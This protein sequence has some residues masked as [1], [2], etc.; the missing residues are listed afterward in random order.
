[1]MFREFSVAYDDVGYR[2]VVIGGGHM[3]EVN[4]LELHGERIAYRDSGQGPAMLLIHGM[5]G[6]SRTWRAV[7]P[8]LSTH[9]RVV[10][11]D[12]VGHG[13]SAKPR[14]DYSLGAF[15][16]WLRDLLDELGI[17]RVTLVGQSLGGGVAMQ[18]VHQHPQY[19]ER[20]VLISSGG[21]GPEVGW[22]LRVMSAPGAE[23]MLPVIAPQFAVA[24][25]ERVRSR[26]SAWGI[27]NARAAETWAAYTSL[28]DPRGREAFLRTLRAVVDHRGQAVSAYSRLGFASGLPALLVWGQDDRIIPATH[29]EAAHL[30]L[31]GSRLTVLPG[32]GHY[33]HVEAADEVVDA[34]EE[35]VMAT[36]PWRWRRHRIPSSHKDAARC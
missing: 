31:P 34:I 14:G 35:F 33:P 7:L 15:A 19:V 32:V 30:A 29:G 21:L 4:Y 22:T 12:L 26:L 23:L 3:A 6:S 11:P 5:A 16:V 18:F 20:L 10:A 9:Y 24:L 27:H 25:G 28:A 8:K 36:A 17:N 2:S 13:L 1:M